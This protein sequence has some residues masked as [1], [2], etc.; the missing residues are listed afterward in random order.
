M[1]KTQINIVPLV[2]IW[3]KAHTSVFFCCF[4]PL[5]FPAPFSSPVLIWAHSEIILSHMEN[6]NKISIFSYSFHAYFL[7]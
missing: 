2:G 5:H 6:I 4:S 7:K 3:K 1:A